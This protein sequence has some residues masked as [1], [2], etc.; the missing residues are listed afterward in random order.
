MDIIWCG[1]HKDNCSARFINDRVHTNIQNDGTLSEIPR[2]HGGMTS[3][4]ELRP[5]ANAARH[6]SLDR[7]HMAKPMSQDACLERDGLRHST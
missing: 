5:I 3:A 2:I 6:G 4:K 1:D 7:T